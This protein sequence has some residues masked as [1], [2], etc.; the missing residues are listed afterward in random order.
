[1]SLST[2]II[3]FWGLEHSLHLSQMEIPGAYPQRKFVFGT[4]VIMIL[5]KIARFL[6]NII[7]KPIY[8]V[9]KVDFVA[10]FRYFQQKSLV[11]QPPP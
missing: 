7:K 4:P 3:E 6:M 10:N 1:M 11:V 2:K 9:F 5:K 8:L